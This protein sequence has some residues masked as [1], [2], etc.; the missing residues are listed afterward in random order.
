[1]WI[2]EI[3]LDGFK[4]Y[5]TRTVVSGFDMQFNAITGLNGTGKSNILDS[6]C[7]VLGIS[8]LSQVRVSNLQELVYKQGQA[9]VTKASVTVVFNNSDKNQ[10]PVGYESFDQI[11][12]GRQVVIGGRNK[13]LINGHNAQQNRVQNLFHSV[14][15]N[16]NNPHFLIMQGRITK[17]L[18]MKPPEILGMIEETA[19]TR[20]F[21]NKKL[22]SLKTIE[23][24]DVKVTEIDRVLTEEITPTLE[25]LRGERKH[26]MEWQ[27]NENEMIGHE[28]I[29][30]AHAYQKA[31]S[32]LKKFQGDLEDMKCREIELD[33]NSD[34]LSVQVAACDEEVATLVKRRDGDMQTA[35]KQY[36]N[37]CGVLSKGLVKITSAWQHKKETHEAEI[38]QRDGLATTSADL[39]QSIVDEQANLVASEEKLAAV[40]AEKQA[41]TDEVQALQTRVQK[42]AAGVAASGDG[43][44]MSWAEALIDAKKQATNAVSGAKQSRMKTQH[45]EKSIAAKTKELSKAGKDFATL[46]KNQQCA[47]QKVV[48]IDD[49]LKAL[50][51]HPEE[52]STLQQSRSREEQACRALRERVDVRAAKLQQ[53]EFKCNMDSSRVKG[54]V[55]PL[56]R[57]HDTQYATALEVAAGGR[58]YNVIVDN[59]RTGADLLKQGLKRRI[60]IIPLARIASKSISDSTVQKAKRLV[61][62]DNVQLALSLVGYDGELHKA[63]E[64]VF[65]NTLVCTDMDAAKKVA[66]DRD[67][68]CKSVT[69]GGDT[70]DPA[71]TLT[72]GARRQTSS[73]L[74]DLAD[75]TELRRELSTHETALADIKARVIALG[76]CEARHEKLSEQ[77][78]LASHEA[79]LLRSRIEASPH[80][81]LAVAVEDMRAQLVTLKDTLAEQINTEKTATARYKELEEQ[82]KN[83]DSQRDVLVKQAEKAVAACKKKL[84]AKTKEFQTC[85]QTTE[86][87]KLELEDLK[88]ELAATVEQQQT[89]GATIDRLQQEVDT[90]CAAVAS[91]TEEYEEMNSLLEEE[92]VKID[93]CDKSVQALNKQRRQLSSKQGNID[94][95]RKRI[96]HKIS[97]FH[98]D[99]SES[100]TKVTQY[101]EQY[102]FIEQERQLFGR[103]GTDFDFKKNN[104]KEARTKH[105]QLKAQQERLSKSINKKVMSMFE[106]AEQEYHTL[107][108][109][110]DIILRDKHKIY[111]VIEE[112]DLKKKVAV[113]TTWKKVNKDFGSI[114]AMLL[115]GA[116]AKVE[117][118]EGMS[119]LEGLEVRVGFGEVWKEGLSELSGGQ[120]SLLALS[121]ILS[122]LLFKPAPMYILDEIDAALDL[123]HTQNIGHMLRTHFTKS[124]FIVVSL[125][126]GMFNNANVVFKTKFVDGVSTVLRTINTPQ[127][128]SSSSS[129]TT[130][131]SSR[132]SSAAD[133]KKAAELKKKA[134]VKRKR[135]GA[136]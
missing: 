111:A 102:P 2:E 7:F 98:K 52:L 112:L 135:A 81:Q 15:L 57:L 65:G 29:F 104:P 37:N 14:Q 72:G 40:G 1:M 68:R 125:K 93:A 58:L 4:S 77:R 8:N 64:Y 9:G 43:E 133:K 46:Q 120:R 25:K 21:E 130:T 45:L 56:V 27:H 91:K 114:F 54:M 107:K 18:N 69:L 55:G 41:F 86:Q 117:P 119:L 82:R 131:T 109:K 31:E 134:S 5:A 24:K 136:V 85:Q 50:S 33:Q 17:V 123:S 28:R 66:F 20:M 73:V 128:T 106:K 92:K 30:I 49:Q 74:K 95:E 34:Q 22:A 62:E 75:L 3:V 38:S 118:P 88:S 60:T 23:K 32:K 105:S 53:F 101:L 51:Y 59:D 127:I 71:G 113:E 63:M 132:S 16:V 48:G 12:V 78:E 87:L 99:Q 103:E 83:A 115:P 110:R 108:E 100:Q 94:L 96:H 26:Y 42:I 126:E 89:I 11:T 97:R 36:D 122:L 80:H 6:I 39:Q 90:L 47:A 84:T 129:T 13:Y 61:G 116:K 79:E 44:D 19:G 10:S 121:L 76:K 124:Q 67:V 70:F 35:Y